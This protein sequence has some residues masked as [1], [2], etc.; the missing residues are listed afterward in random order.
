MR[1]ERVLW[2]EPLNQAP[3]IKANKIGGLSYIEWNASAL[4]IRVRQTNLS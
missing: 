2:K 1:T 4:T 3:K